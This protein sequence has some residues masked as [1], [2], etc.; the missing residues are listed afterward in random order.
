M[1]LA[2]SA[3]EKEAHITPVIESLSSDDSGLSSSPALSHA[4]TIRADARLGFPQDVKG[5]L[6]DSRQA[7]AINPNNGRAYRVLADAEEADGDVAAAIDAT[8][9]WGELDPS[10]ATKARN[11]VARLSKKGR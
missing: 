2:S 6:E 3:S 4:L 8:S 11:E 10:F 1:C 5:A 7:A 9:R